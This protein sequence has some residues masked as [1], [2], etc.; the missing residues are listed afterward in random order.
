MAR[1]GLTA[2][3]ASATSLDQMRDLAAATRL[4]LDR[5]DIERLDGASAGG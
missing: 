5:G 1:P 3:I 2:P 4:R